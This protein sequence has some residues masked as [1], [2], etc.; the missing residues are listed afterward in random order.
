MDWRIGLSDRQTFDGF[1]HGR[2]IVGLYAGL[3]ELSCLRCNGP[4]GKALSRS[5]L[6]IRRV[7]QPRSGNDRL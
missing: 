2:W 4:N 3:C 5:L 1:G 7:P 6:L